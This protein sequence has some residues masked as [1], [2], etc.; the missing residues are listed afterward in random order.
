MVGTHKLKWHLKKVP[1]LW[2]YQNSIKTSTLFTHFQ[3]VYRL[4]EVL[5]IE[6]EIPSLQ[7]SIEL[8]PNTSAEE[9]QFL[10]L[11]KLDETH[12]GVALAN[13]AHKQHIKV[14]YEKSIHPRI[15]P[16]GDLVLVYDQANDKLR[17]GKLEPMWHGPYVVKRALQKGAYEFV[18]Y[19]GIPLK[20]PHNGIYLKKCYA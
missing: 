9:E 4:E 20:V 13:K 14:Q 15:F 6:C 7:L 12:H 16:E 18:D 8:F 2:A 5:P 11:E 10:Y 3:L 17:V 19:H 1:A